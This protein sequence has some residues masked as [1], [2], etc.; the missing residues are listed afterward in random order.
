MD[1]GTIIFFT[2]A[3]ILFILPFIYWAILNGSDKIANGVRYKWRTI[4]I[5]IAICWPLSF[6]IIIISFIFFGQGSSPEEY[7]TIINFTIPYVIGGGV[8]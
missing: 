6:A 5:L 1:A 2:I 3:I 4:F 7:S 8:Y